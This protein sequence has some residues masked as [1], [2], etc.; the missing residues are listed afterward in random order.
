MLEFTLI[1][2]VHF[3]HALLVMYKRG[4]VGEL[5]N[6]IAKP[7]GRCGRWL[8]RRACNLLTTLHPVL[9][10]R[11]GPFRLEGGIDVWKLQRNDDG[12]GSSDVCYD[13]G[14]MTS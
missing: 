3:P 9:Y 14:Y 7:P 12:R 11:L 6:L 10:F 1:N 2:G 5:C 13:H 8:R 4:T